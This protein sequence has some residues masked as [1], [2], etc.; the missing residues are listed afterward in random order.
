MRQLMEQHDYGQK[1]LSRAAGLNERAV[2][3]MLNSTDN[4]GVRTLEAIAQVFGMTL[5]EL[6]DGDGAGRQKVR[7]MGAVAAGEAWTVY[8]D[9]TDEIEMSISGGEP[10]ALEVRG[11][12]MV[13]VYRSGDIIAGAKRSDAID[14]FLGRD[15]I[16]QTDD[17]GRYLKIVAKAAVRGRFNLKSY[18][19]LVD[20]IANVRIAWAAPVEWIRRG[21]R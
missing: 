18:N 10:V 17:C 20:D 3:Q 4:P 6:Y 13:P 11:D 12:S 16:V 1:P 21:R 8:D 9:M 15:C 7:V 14:E 5:G 2:G 19:P